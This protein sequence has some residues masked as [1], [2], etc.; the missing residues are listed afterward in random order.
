MREPSMFI[1]GGRERRRRG[2]PALH[3]VKADQR[4]EFTVTAEQRRELDRVAKESGKALATVIR[5]AVNEFVADY[6][7]RRVF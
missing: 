1:V 3:G 2:R 4:V 5:E 6:S 7:D